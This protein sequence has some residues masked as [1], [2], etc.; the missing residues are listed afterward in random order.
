M[1]AVINL[2]HCEPSVRLCRTSAAASSFASIMPVMPLPEHYPGLDSLFGAKATPCL[3]ALPPA[4]PHSL[5]PDDP[6]ALTKPHGAGGGCLHALLLPLD[7][8][9]HT[10]HLALPPLPYLHH[11]PLII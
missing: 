9:A 7:P 5:L 4:C 10:P 6:S 11:I 2:H 8:P 1:H 3:P